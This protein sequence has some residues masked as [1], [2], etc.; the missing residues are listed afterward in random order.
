MVVGTA[1]TD[2]DSLNIR[3]NMAGLYSKMAESEVKS[4]VKII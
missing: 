4:K 2:K 1:D 3:T